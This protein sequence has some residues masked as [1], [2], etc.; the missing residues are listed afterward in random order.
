MMACWL[1]TTSLRHGSVRESAR[2]ALVN[3]LL[4]LPIHPPP[5]RDLA[6]LHVDLH[7][8][9]NAVVATVA[10]RDVTVIVADLT[11]QIAPSVV[12]SALGLLIVVQ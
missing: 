11:V 2:N 3:G 9:A 12:R 10:A 6:H 7:P 4:L 8:D 1:M 5:I